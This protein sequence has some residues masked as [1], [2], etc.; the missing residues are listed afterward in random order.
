MAD[1]REELLS[2]I[3]KY[4]GEVLE[5]YK[6]TTTAA[7]LDARKAS[8]FKK[9]DFAGHVVHFKEHKEEALSITPEQIE[10]PSD[11]FETKKIVE[12][13]KKSLATFNGLCDRDIEF[14]DFMDR[15]QKR[16]DGINVKNYKEVFGAMQRAMLSAHE[17]LGFLDTAYQKYQ[18]GETV[19]EEGETVGEQTP[20]TPVEAPVEKKE[21]QLR[22][23]LDK[24]ID[25]DEE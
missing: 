4:Y 1:Y 21:P 2:Q 7:M 17:A 12:I 22:R 25:I 5:K 13:F 9:K 14:Y 11:D 15:K 23:I 20:E 6:V 10:I 3:E 19:F 18:N 8:L 16:E 24:D